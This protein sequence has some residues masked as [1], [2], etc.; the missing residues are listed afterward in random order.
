MK[1]RKSLYRDITM[2]FDMIEA[3]HE[4]MTITELLMVMYWCPLSF[5]VFTNINQTHIW[6]NEYTFCI[7]DCCQQAR[8]RGEM[9]NLILCEHSDNECHL[10]V[11]SHISF[12]KLTIVCC[13][14]NGLWKLTPKKWQEVY[15]PKMARSLAPKNDKKCV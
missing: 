11:E 12:H 13:N 6:N 8:V 3:T 14:K 5:F 9:V 4:D 10:S 15:L 7:S 1:W 2:A